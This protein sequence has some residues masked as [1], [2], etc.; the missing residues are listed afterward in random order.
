M[1]TFDASFSY[2]NNFLSDIFLI[3]CKQQGLAII[4]G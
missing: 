4:L 3:Y 1:H 2:T